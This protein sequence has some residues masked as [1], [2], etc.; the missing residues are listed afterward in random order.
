METYETVPV[1]QLRSRTL[2]MV[3]NVLQLITIL[4][5]VIY[6]FWLEHGYQIEET[7][8]GSVSIKVKGAGHTM[9]DAASAGTGPLGRIRVQDAVD[10]VYPPK[11]ENALFLTTNYI[12]VP[13]QGRGRCPSRL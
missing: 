8:L 10:I 9:L 3:N 1:I 2:S 11:E 12:D 6:I 4:Y 5:V 7:G 13:K